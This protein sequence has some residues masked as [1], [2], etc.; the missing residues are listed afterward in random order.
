MCRP[1][2][3]L[4]FERGAHHLEAVRVELRTLLGTG[5]PAIELRDGFDADDDVGRTPR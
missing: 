4:K 2:R 3:W 1:G 5:G